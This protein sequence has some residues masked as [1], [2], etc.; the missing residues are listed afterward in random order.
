M[1]SEECARI[2]E[3]RASVVA[4]LR[5]I[6]DAGSPPSRDLEY[7]LLVDRLTAL[8]AEARKNGCP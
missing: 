3:K 5:D 6:E 4:K 8:D 7:E 2:G 1:L